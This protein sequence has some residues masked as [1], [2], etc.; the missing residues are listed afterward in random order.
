[1]K[2]PTTQPTT[3]GTAVKK[4]QPP[5]PKSFQEQQFE[6]INPNA[7]GIDVA[8]EEMWVCVPASRAE[9]NVQRFGAF[10]EDLYAIA[11]WLTECDITSVAMESTGVY[12]IPLYQVLEERGFEVCLTNAHHLK[13]VS[14]RPKTDRLDCQWIQRLHSYGFLPAS[15]RPHDAICRI[16]TIQRHRDSLIR[17]ASRHVQH[18]QKALHQ[19]NVLLPKVV[20]DITGVTGMTIMQRI[21][22]GERDPVQLA[23]LRNPHCK[24]SEAT[25][26]K[27]LRGDYREEHLFVLQQAHAGY[28]FVHTQ[29]LACDHAI[30]QWLTVIETQVDAAHTPMPPRTKTPQSPR[31]NQ[32]TFTGDARTMLYERFGTDVTSLTGIDTGIGLALYTEVGADMRPWPTEKHFASWLGLS[33]NARSSGG[34][35]KSSQTRDVA[36][37]AALAFRMAAKAASGSKTYIGAFY[38][39]K[40]ARIGAPKAMTATAR[41]IAVIFYH[42]VKEHTPYHDF[43]ETYYHTRDRER[44]VTRLRRQAARLG[45]TVMEPPTTSPDTGQ[46]TTQ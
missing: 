40:K 6:M 12:W 24:S 15:F 25:I 18:M 1:M 45:F 9:Q 46:E 5:H 17:D 35:T 2:T 33:P 34:K 43:G 10:T 7:A 3:A 22:D 37:R 36:S 23:T 20:T 8:T 29:M 32:H 13:N 44:A 14:G 11:Q 26:A 27:A 30:E 39:R 28:R 31:K 4:K 19:M 16:R 38:R 21:L 41:K 42:M